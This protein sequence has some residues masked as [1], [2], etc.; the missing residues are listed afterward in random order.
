MYKLADQS[1]RWRSNSREILAGAVSENILIYAKSMLPLL[2][3]NVLL[4]ATCFE[5]EKS[6]QREELLVPALLRFRR[7]KVVRKQMGACQFHI[8]TTIERMQTERR[9]TVVHLDD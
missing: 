4:L 1:I 5:Q 6:L 9:T 8:T 7:I 3:W 2:V